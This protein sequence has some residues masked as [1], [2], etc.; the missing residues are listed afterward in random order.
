MGFDARELALIEPLRTLRMMHHSAWIAQRWSDPAFPVAFPWF[1]SAAYWSQQTAAMREQIEAMQEARCRSA[2]RWP[3]ASSQAQRRQQAR[4]A[5]HVRGRVLELAAFGQQR[6][7]EQDV[8]QVV[9]LRRV[10][11]KPLDQRML[12]R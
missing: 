10:V 4:Y 8:R 2:R 5:L 6:L 11:F 1:G 7:V 12:R 9:E 3:A